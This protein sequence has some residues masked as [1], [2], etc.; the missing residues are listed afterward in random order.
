MDGSLRGD[1]GGG[2]ARVKVRVTEVFVKA[3]VSEGARERA[4]FNPQG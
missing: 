2:G 4:G 1:V 3:I